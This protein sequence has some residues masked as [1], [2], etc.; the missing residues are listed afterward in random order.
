MS[1]AKG[2]VRAI[3]ESN[4]CSLHCIDDVINLD[5]CGAKEVAKID[6]D[7]HRWYV[8][9]TKVFSVGKEFFGVRGVVSLKSEEMSYDDC[10]VTCEA[11]EMEAVPSVTYQ[12]K[13]IG[14]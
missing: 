12:I 10:C 13:G 4:L 14:K 9:A 8:I 6:E 5:A 1:T 7:E 11:F 3:N 2:L